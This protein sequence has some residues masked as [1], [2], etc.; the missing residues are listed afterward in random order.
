[1]KAPKFLFF[2]IM[3]ALIGCHTLTK[4]EILISNP[5]DY[6]ERLPSMGTVFEVQ[7]V[8]TCGKPDPDKIL[9]LAKEELDQMETAMSLYQSESEISRLNRVGSVEASQHF[10][11]VVN[12]SL[13]H[14]QLT[15]G[16]FDITIWPVL[17]LIQKSLK[18]SN[19]PPQKK[20]LESLRELVDFKNVSV[21]GKQIKFKKQGMAISLDGVA[22]GYAVDV[23]AEKLRLS[24]I[25]S[26]IVNFSGNMRIEGR[27]ADGRPWSLAVYDPVTEA[28]VKIP[29]AS[30]PLSV[31]SSGIDF[32]SYSKDKLWH[33]IINPKTL[34]PANE[35]IATSI[36]GPSATVCDVLS[37]ATFAMGPNQ[38]VR[39]LLKNYPQ[40]RYRLETRNGKIT[41]NL[42]GAN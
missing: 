18:V 39:I 7:Y 11:N 41:T 15:E 32:A 30:T 34:R 40:Y 37:T 24:G 38:A 9:R 29:V 5:C 17:K 13:K 4:K 33:H 2:S 42:T 36:V 28:V 25:L 20:Q 35:L 26:F 19:Q 1:V 8:D 14:G 31:A 10:I 21:L 27:H 3:A 12:E 22:K 16:Y 6:V 23:I